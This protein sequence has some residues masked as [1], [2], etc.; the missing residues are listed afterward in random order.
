MKVA[1]L[2]AFGIDERIIAL[3]Q[4][5][6]HTALLPIQELAVRQGGVLNGKNVLVFSPTSSG[7]TFVGETAA[8]RTALRNRRVVYLVPQKALAEEKYHAFHA[9]YRAFGIRTVVSTRDRKEFD[10]SIARGA[11]HI[12]VVVFEKMQSLLLTCPGLLRNVGLVVVDELQMI[13]DKTRGAG[14]EILLN[15]MKLAEGNP[16]IIGLSAVLRNSRSLARWLGAELCESRE[17]PVE[18]RKGVLWNG[19]FHYIEH[20]RREP[21]REKLVPTP[22]DTTP[23]KILIRQVKA[24]AEAGE[25]CLV[26]CKSKQDCIR[27]ATAVAAVLKKKPAEGALA[28]VADLEDS[29]GKDILAK[30]L[31]RGVAY[32]NADLDWDQRDI[33]ERRFRSG[34]IAVICATTTLAMGI[35]LPAKN[36]FIDPERWDRDPFGHWSTIP[37]SQSEYENTGGRAGRLGL[38]QDFGRAILVSDSQF[39]ARVYYRTFV[40]GTLGDVAPALNDDPLAH[41]VLNLVAS[42][43]CRTEPDIRKVLLASYTGALCWRGGEREAEFEGRLKEAVE[44]CLAG[45]LIRA[46]EDTL[47]A[48]EL[49]RL[50]AIKGISVDTAI[51]LA[52]FAGRY[53]DQASDLH[54]LE[55]LLCLTGTEDGQ[56]VYFN[57]STDEYRSRHYAERL[58]ALLAALPPAVG[59]RLRETESLSMP[60]YE[61]TKRLKKTLILYDWAESVPT[62]EVEDR[63]RCFAGGI[64][65]LAQEF[66]WLAEALAA[67]TEICGWPAGAVKRLRA[68]TAQLSHGVP[69]NAVEI[70]AASV[71]GLGRGRIKGLLEQGL[72]SL[73]KVVAAPRD[74]IEKLVTKPVARRLL[75]RAKSLLL[76]KR[77]EEQAKGIDAGAGPEAAEE[78]AQAWPSEVPPSDA[79]GTP[80]RSQV[81]VTLDG[82]LERRRYRVCVDAR[83][84]WLTERSFEVLLKLAV[85]AL[86][87]ELGWVPGTK[88]GEMDTYHQVIRRLKRGLASGGVDPEGLIEND[89]SKQY[90][91]SV[92]PGNIAVNTE[93]I[94][95]NAPEH[96]KLLLALESRQK[97]SA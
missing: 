9:K 41:H 61:E 45:D 30:L 78:V 3:W 88:F 56:A 92:P 64:A 83:E 6:G 12:A 55:V 97:E 5:A 57:L 33:I 73:D 52:R 67:V 24:F 20:N 48:T 38:A 53:K 17:R 69:E 76:R 58:R 27:T 82:R 81:S 59:E 35:N 86:V 87:T 89:G 2:E 26:F 19:E 77:R 31:T 62:R 32:H 23:D 90:R 21:G 63:F 44:H 65:G 47:T 7:K 50:A 80:Y 1:L 13:G 75:R 68:L 84:V 74:Q 28:E 4:Q 11:F 39:Q 54:L 51:A 46:A 96:M 14:L 71:R 49:G 72:D 36:V 42:G 79:A 18:L 37:I 10:D 29:K 70:V 40:R 95:Q 15:K 85:A 34:E 94:G 91:L 60:D 8:V 22:K 43:I 25:P 16:Q 93:T 66:S